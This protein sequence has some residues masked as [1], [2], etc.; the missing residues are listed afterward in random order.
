MVYFFQ[1]TIKEAVRAIEARLEPNPTLSKCGTL[2][3]P[4]SVV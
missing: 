2:I 3:R 1:K 4:A